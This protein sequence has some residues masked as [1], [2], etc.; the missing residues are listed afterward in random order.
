MRALLMLGI[1]VV[2]LGCASTTQVAPSAADDVGK[3]TYFDENVDGIVDYEYHDFI[4]CDRNWALVDTDF[5]GYFDV[6]AQW[7]Y[8]YTETPIHEQVPYDVVIRPG[9]SG[10]RERHQ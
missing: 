5:D 10:W 2:L 8:S 7:G 6:R 1:A 9:K 3:V 4:C